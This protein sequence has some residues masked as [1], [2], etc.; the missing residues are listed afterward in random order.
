MQ[1][2]LLSL[3][4]LLLA[5]CPTRSD[6]PRNDDDSAGDDDLTFPQDDDDSAGDDDDLTFPQDDDDSADDD[7]DASSRV[8]GSLQGEQLGGGLFIAD[9][10]DDGALDLALG[11]PGADFAGVDSGAL[12]I[13]FGAPPAG[14]TTTSSAVLGI[15]PS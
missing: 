5:A 6:F 12:Y 1:R 15:E 14:P 7:D 9:L 8:D 3:L 13:F 11:A 2:S 4:I 10:D